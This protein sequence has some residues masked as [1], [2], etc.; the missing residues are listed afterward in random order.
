MEFL[1]EYLQGI[2]VVL[3]G[4]SGLIGLIALASPTAFASI[5]TYGN[6]VVHDGTQ[7]RF[8]LRWT[9]IDE[10]VLVHGRIFGLAVVATVGYLWAISY[11]GPEAYSKSFWLV[12]V[13][14]P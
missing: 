6:R 1:V 8:D 9:G 10:F 2:V 11:Y 3:L 5:A 12:I 13:A 7:T 4:I 14:L